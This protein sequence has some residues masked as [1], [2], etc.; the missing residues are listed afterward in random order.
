MLGS[1]NESVIL[2]LLNEFTR[3]VLIANLTAWPAA[4]FIM[5]K[6]LQRY[7]YRISIGIVIFIFSSGAAF[8]SAILTVGYQAVKSANLN[9]VDALKYE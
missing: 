2:M 3:S 1:S 5:D 4:Y 7:V 6:L 9:P 8:L